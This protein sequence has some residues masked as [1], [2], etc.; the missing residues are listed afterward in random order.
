MT[1]IQHI[2]GP[3]DRNGN[4]RRLFLVTTQEP[5]RILAFDEGYAGSR[6]IPDVLSHTAPTPAHWLP[7]INVSATEYRRILKMYEAETAA[8]NADWRVF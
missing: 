5:A 6:A 3:H 4:P 2:C 7:S 8:F 1:T